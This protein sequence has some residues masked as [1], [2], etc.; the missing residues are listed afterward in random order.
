MRFY[1]VLACFAGLPV[2][3]MAQ[4]PRPSSLSPMQSGGGPAPHAPAPNTAGGAVAAPA[5]SQANAPKISCAK[6]TFDFGS[7]DEGPNIDHSFIIRNRGRGDLKITHVGTSCGCT[8]SAVEQNGVTKSPTDG[9]PLIVPPG[10]RCTIKAT[11]HTQ[12]R[13]GHAEKIITVTSNDPLNPQFQMHLTM[14]VVRE[15]DVNPDRLYLYNVRHGQGRDTGVTITG[16]PGMKLSILSAKTE[17]NKVTLGPIQPYNDEK[18]GKSG[19]SFTVSLPADY[20]IGSFTDTID[21]STDNPKKPEIKIDV[22][23]EVVGRVT[24][25]PKQ[26]FFPPNSQAPVT[27]IMTVDQPNGFAVRRVESV[28]HLVRAYVKPVSSGYG[29]QQ[30]YLIAEP[31]G[32]LPSDSDGKDQ[33][34]V[35]TNDNEQQGVTIDAQINK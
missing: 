18:E 14:T 24:Y 22:L 29:N 8:T 4:A 33:V 16:K 31:S 3:A 35:W 12:G 5:G 10:G 13:P 23:G 1:I 25:S 20:P 9:D 27:L 11:Y 26:L 34:V 32:H 28:K 2:M 19:A 30:Y 15:V 21:V 6:T 7:V 17:N